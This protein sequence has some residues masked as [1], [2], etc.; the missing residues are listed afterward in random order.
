MTLSDKKM[1]K[2]DLHIKAFKGKYISGVGC[3]PL[4][5][6]K[7]P[8]LL[9]TY[10]DSLLCTVC[11]FSKGL[12]YMRG[13]CGATEKTCNTWKMVADLCSGNLRECARY[14]FTTDILRLPS[15]ARD[16]LRKYF[17]DKFTGLNSLEAVY[18]VLGPSHTSRV[19]R[20]MVRND[21]QGTIEEGEPCLTLPLHSDPGQV[22][23][24]YFKGTRGGEVALYDGPSNM[25]GSYLPVGVHRR[26]NEYHCLQSLITEGT[27][28]LLAGKQVNLIFKPGEM[29]D[30]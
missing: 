8:S 16:P 3:C 26:L 19:S 14:G 18:K 23:G 7:T 6:S 29:Y 22:C 28:L 1:V 20:R 25:I 11:G 5:A 24:L 2:A 15:D 13:V 17:Y 4:C 21:I 9:L 12:S 10:A 30:G 27:T